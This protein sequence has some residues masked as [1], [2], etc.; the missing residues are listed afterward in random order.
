MTTGLYKKG[1]VLGIIILLIGVGILPAAGAIKSFEKIYIVSNPIS[2]GTITVD[3]EGDGDY[4]NIQE[5]IDNANPADTIEVYS[6]TYIENVIVNKQFNLVGVDSEL[7]DGNDIGNP[8]IDGGNS[9]DV[10][11]VSAD[12][13]NI[14]G[15]TIQNSG[16][17]D[18]PDYDAG[19]D[20]RSNYNNI[21]NNN[22]SNNL[23]GIYTWNSCNNEFSKNIISNVWDGIFLDLYSNNSLIVDNV[24]IDHLYDGIYIYDH[25]SN[26]TIHKNYFESNS[27]SGIHIKKYSHHNNIS[28]NDVYSNAISYCILIAEYS[29]HNEIFENRLYYGTNGIKLDEASTNRIIENHIE[30]CSISINMEYSTGLEIFRNNLMAR[31]I[32]SA[33]LN[34]RFIESES[35]ELK[36]NFW[37]EHPKK[38]PPNRLLGWRVRG[39]I[40]IPNLKNVDRS[41]QDIPYPYV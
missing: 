9:G 13:V 23:L 29:N 36:G 18:W 12:K 26:N 2:T 34:A 40:Y 11:Y 17:K 21:A 8:V 20:I 25:S 14:S 4:T 30:E 19:I 28:D 33:R 1:I 10:F 24:L 38:F 35:N 22:I 15:F 37:S 16:N 31:E 41:P 32:T 39:I 6:G 3:D 7:G 5:A 27:Q